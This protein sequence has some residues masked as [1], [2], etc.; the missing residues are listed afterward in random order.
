MHTILNLK[1]YT[2][3]GI[4]CAPG[5]QQQAHCVYYVPTVHTDVPQLSITSECYSLITNE[6]T[7]QVAI[8]CYI[9]DKLCQV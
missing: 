8:S 4:G 1:L 9:N 5:Y 2:S 7:L 3:S 6:N